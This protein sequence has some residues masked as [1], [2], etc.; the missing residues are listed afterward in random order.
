MTLI[1]RK[2]GSSVTGRKR[3][4]FVR[5]TRGLK[6]SRR[7]RRLDMLPH[8]Y[9]RVVGD[10]LWNYVQTSS[11]ASFSNGVIKN[12][13][14][15]SSEISFSAAFQMNDLPNWSEFSNLYDQYRLNYVVLT[16]KLVNNPDAIYVPNVAQGAGTVNSSNWYPTIWMVRDHDDAG[17]ISLDAIKQYSTVRHKV[18][19]PNRELKLTIKPST[20]VAQYQGTNVVPGTVQ[21]KKWIDVGY[22][23]INHYGAK[24]VVDFEGLTTIAA[25]QWS[26]K[27]DAKYYFQMKVAR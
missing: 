20:V 18:L 23:N 9:V 17:T 2:R 26:I 4:R 19:V 16:I 24:F 8:S 7:V 3:G 22:P 25:N 15:G 21:Y 11:T 1:K 6:R 27:L 5:R 10:S 13:M 12:S 14:I